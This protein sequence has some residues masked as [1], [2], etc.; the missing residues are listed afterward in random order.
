METEGQ[1][2]QKSNGGQERKADCTGVNVANVVNVV[3]REQVEAAVTR[4]HAIMNCRVTVPVTQL[5]LVEK[6]IRPSVRPTI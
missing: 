4:S 2:V 1:T 6:V 3:V 5:D